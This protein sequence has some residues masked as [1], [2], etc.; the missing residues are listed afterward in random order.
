MSVIVKGHLIMPKDELRECK[1]IASNNQLSFPALK[2]LFMTHTISLI[3]VLTEKGV[4]LNQPTVCY[5][6]SGMSSCSLVLAIIYCGGQARLYS[7]SNTYLFL[8]L[9]NF[10]II[11]ISHFLR[12]KTFIFYLFIGWIQRMEK[13]NI[14]CRA[15]T[16]KFIK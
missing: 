7:V 13:K 5:C 10:W 2:S 11:R 3:L 12:E 14:Q 15:P 6:N 4:K 16:P 1:R 8:I 9:D